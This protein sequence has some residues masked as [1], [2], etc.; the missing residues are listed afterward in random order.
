MKGIPNWLWIVV[1]LLAIVGVFWFFSDII[2]YLLIAGVISLVSNPLV[3]LFQKIRFGRVQ[4][5]RPVGAFFTILTLYLLIAGL[6]SLFI[7]LV[8]DEYRI[9]SS[10]NVREIYNGLEGPML[11]LQQ[12]LDK[13]ELSKTPGQ[14]SSEY[15]QEQLLAFIK[16]TDITNIFQNLFGTLGNVL[17][18]L[19]IVTFIL[20]FFLKEENMFYRLVLGIVPVKLET[21]F[22]NIWNHSRQLLRR[23]FVGIMIQLSLI[24]TLVAS[25]MWMLGVDNALLIGFFAG[26]I[27]II[28]YVGP[29]IGAMFGILIG[30]SVNLHLPFYPEMTLLIGKMVLVFAVVQVMDNFLFQPFIFSNSVRAHPLEIFIVILAAASMGGIAG[31]ILAIPVYTIVRVVAREFFSE[32]KVVKNLTEEM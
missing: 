32:W 18:G 15:L 5:S 17:L 3:E 19:F 22:S 26:L 27:N 10:I 23:Y 4:V 7:P 29:L 20:F 8:L 6:M 13:Y 28:P 25:G 14:S 11:Q 9:M 30:I 16:I 1:G 31:M 21:H 12:L 24:A 2:T